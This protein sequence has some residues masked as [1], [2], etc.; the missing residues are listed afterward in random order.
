MAVSHAILLS[1]LFA[2]SV[3]KVFGATI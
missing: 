3:R 1:S 2:S